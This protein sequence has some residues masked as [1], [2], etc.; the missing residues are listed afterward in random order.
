MSKKT[1]QTLKKI[2][3]YYDFSKHEAQHYNTHEETYGAIIVAK[4]Y[5]KVLLISENGIWGFPKGHRN[6]GENE[7]GAAIRKVKEI[8]ITIDSGDFILNDKGDPLTY[9]IEYPWKYGEDILIYHISRIL[10]KQKTCPS[11]R[12]HWNRVGPM[13]KRITLYLVP[14]EM[15]RFKQGASLPD[16]EIPK[17]EWVSWDEAFSRMV[18]GSI[19]I[20]ALVAAFNDLQKMRKIPKDQ[21]LP[22]LTPKIKKDIR[23]KLAK[24]ANIMAQ[25]IKKWQ[26][27]PKNWET[28]INEMKGVSRPMPNE[29]EKFLK[30]DKHD[31]KNAKADETKDAKD[32]ETKANGTKADKDANDETKDA[33]DDELDIDETDAE[34]SLEESTEVKN[35]KGGDANDKKESE[36]FEIL[37][38]EILGL[39]LGLIVIGLVLL[40][41]WLVRNF[42]LHSTNETI[43][44]R[45]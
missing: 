42:A 10:E 16:A 33:K 31:K 24:E 18:T 11:E 28:I 37:S 3:K 15:D 32:D 20:E 44:E 27:Q 2:N 19:Y 22:N 7:I 35:I 40:L 17:I 23:A 8:N 38:F 39:I 5:D 9:K 1:I 14:V 30:K 4:S 43:E 25:P 26:K 6:D 34:E 45:V 21:H 12:P 29:K 41:F 36:P 13:K